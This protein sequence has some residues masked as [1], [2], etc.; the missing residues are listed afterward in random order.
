MIDLA[1][2]AMLKPGTKRRKIALLLDAIERD[3][4]DPASAPK[5]SEVPPQQKIEYLKVLCTIVARDPKLDLP[6]RSKLDKLIAELP[7]AQN[8]N[9]AA[10]RACNCA[11]NALLNILGIPSGE[12]Q[13]VIAPHDNSQK[14]RTIHDGMFLFAEDIRSPFN[15]GSIY[16]CAECLGVNKIYVSPSCVSVDNPRAKRSAM[17][18]I[19]MLGCN[20]LPLEEVIALHPDSAVFALETGGIPINDFQFPQ[21]GICVVGSEELG[22]SPESLKL[23]DNIVTIPMLGVKA[24]LNV[25]CACAILL[26]RWATALSTKTTCPQE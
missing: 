15:I 8:D 18:T 23:V 9:E 21:K 2:L 24:S 22:V 4:V 5:N 1:K 19:E 10:R 16:R 14:T 25:S 6:T 3:I 7:P 11:R 20:R 12:W 17:G 13:L 26:E